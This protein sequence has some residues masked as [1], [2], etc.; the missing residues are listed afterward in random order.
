MTTASS[1]LP[2][3]SALAADAIAITCPPLPGG[4]LQLQSTFKACGTW[5]SDNA[6]AAVGCVFKTAGGATFNPTSMIK[7]PPPINTWSATFTIPAGT[8]G[9]LHSFIK[10]NGVETASNDV[11][12]LQVVAAGGGTC[13]C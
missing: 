2:K 8:N 5:S 13:N 3:A 9:T 7:T 10:V 11:A 12:N 4:G 1:T 6:Q